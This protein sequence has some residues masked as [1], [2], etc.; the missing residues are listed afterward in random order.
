MYESFDDFE[1]DQEK[2]DWTFRVRGFDFDTAALVFDD[3][4]T[5]QEDEREDYG[6]PRYVVTGVVGDEMSV[7]VVVWTPRGHKRRIISA[8]LAD[9]K[10][11]EEYGKF[12][13]AL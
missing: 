10:E 6:E 11:R 4:Y 7:L 13:G 3:V 2:S 5:E 1:W 9:Q 8:R 12:R